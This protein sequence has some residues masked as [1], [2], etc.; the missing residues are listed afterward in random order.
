MEMLAG[1]AM[2][3]PGAW[4]RRA[5][6]LAC[7][8]AGCA[9]A[10]KPAV[11]VPAVP[12]DVAAAARGALEQWRQ[13]YQVRSFEA[14]ADLYARDGSLT[15]VQDGTLWLGWAAFEPVLRDRLAKA[16]AI[17]V[18]LKDVAVTAVGSAGA[19]VV[20]TMARERADATTQIMENGVL[21]LVLRSS[22]RA[23]SGSSGHPAWVIVAEHYS[24]KRT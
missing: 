2:A 6:A 14:L 22:G 8:L 11:A 4:G 19:V 23:G 7:V 21:T 13:A 15:V 16:T 20:A 24:Y 12:A 18:R 1:V 17:H 9:T 5:L 3:A 10:D